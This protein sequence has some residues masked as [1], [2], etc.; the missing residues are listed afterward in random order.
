MISRR[1]WPAL[2]LALFCLPLFLGLRNNDLIGDE[3][4]HSFSVDRILETGTWLIPKLSPFPNVDFL[5]KPPLKFWIVAAGI[6]AGLPHDEFGLRFWDALFASAAFLYLFGIGRRLA[7]PWCGAV[8]VMILFVQGPLMSIHGIRTNNMEAALLLC[9][10]GGFYHYFAWASAGDHS[11]RLWHPIAI[12]LYFSFGFMMKFVAALFLPMVL[13]LASLLIGTYRKRLV[14][15]WRIWLSAGAVALVLA[16]PWYVYATIR[17]G[18]AFWNVIFG[19]HVYTRFT[20][21]LDPAHVHPWNYYFVEMS[22][23]LSSSN[24]AWL[25][26]VGAVLLVAETIRRRSA[27]GLVVI[28]WFAVPIA[29]I[30]CGSSKLDHY[31]LPFL[32]PVGLAGGYFIGMIAMAVSPRVDRALGRVGHFTEWRNSRLAT[33]LSLPALR[34]ACLVFAVLSMGVLVSTV[35]A[36]PLTLRII[37]GFVFRNRDLLRPGLVSAVLFIL[38]GW[39]QGIGRLG[40]PLLI[41]TVLPTPAY[42]GTLADIQSG[43]P[44]L[45]RV[46]DCVVRIGAQPEQM[47]SGPRGLYVDI[48]GPDFFQPFNHQY[49]YYFR[50][51]TPWHRPSQTPPELLHRFFFDPS[52]QRPVLMSPKRYQA[53]SESFAGELD[54]PGAPRVAVFEPAVVLV[55]SGAYRVCSPDSLAAAEA[56]PL[57]RGEPR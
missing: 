44:N 43:T 27:E 53:L 8:A 18:T 9:Y 3:A 50:G 2:V 5:E 32:P 21:Y 48:D 12:A 7:G 28:L 38:G 51:V 33:W 13:G 4:A 16:V 56:G 30:S 11:R 49:T 22:R 6:R 25:V 42:R 41:V 31:A 15:D 35:V 1:V 54:L 17:F 57:N 29:I 34:V 39:P 47:M 36:G 20:L 24:T 14:E 45:R 52:E 40:I 10:C 55:L 26:I 37:D 46:R 23:A 19:A